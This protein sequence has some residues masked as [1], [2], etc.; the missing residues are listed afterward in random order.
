MQFCPC[1]KQFTWSV[2]ER[3]HTV[4]LALPCLTYTIVQYVGETVQARV[5]IKSIM[6]LNRF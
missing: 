4:N 3:C 1:V 2:F 5:N 6:L